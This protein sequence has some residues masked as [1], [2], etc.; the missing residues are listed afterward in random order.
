[1]SV[2]LRDSRRPRPQRRLAR[3][4]VFLL[5]PLV[6]VPRV[7][8]AEQASLEYPVKAAFL[9]NFAKF[10]EWPA[11][12]SQAVAGT[13]SICVLGR[14]PFG[15]SLDRIVAGRTAGGR[16]IEVRRYSEPAGIETCHVLFVT[17]AELARSPGVLVKL[18]DKPVLTVGESDDFVRRGG[19]IR[20]FV[21]SNRARFEVSLSATAAAGLTLSSKLLGVARVVDSSQEQR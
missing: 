8:A 15:D 18:R 14:D 12:S 20:F 4:A 21:E 5:A 2:M 19:A 1:M 11:D 9:L 16:P 17:S 7:H 3:A 10:T 6:L 13:V